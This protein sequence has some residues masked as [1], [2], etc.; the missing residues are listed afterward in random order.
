MRLNVTPFLEIENSEVRSYSLRVETRISLNDLSRHTPWVG[1][2]CRTEA[3]PQKIRNES[4][5]LEEYGVSKWGRVRDFL[6]NGGDPT[7]ENLIREQGADPTKLVP[8]S[9]GSELF[10]STVHDVLAE[11]NDLVVQTLAEAVAS[12]HGGKPP[13]ALVELGSGFGD[14]VVM[15]TGALKPVQ[16]IGGEFTESGVEAGT[17]LAQRAGLSNVTFRHFDFNDPATC[18]WI[19]ENA[20]V[21]SLHA[22][23]QIP[24]LSTG[25]LRAIA[26]RKPRCVV[27]LEPLF[28]EKADTLLGTM[29]K[30]YTILNDYNRDL[31]PA[32]RA[33]ETEGVVEITRVKPNLFG[34]VPLNPTSLIQWRARG[35]PSW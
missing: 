32:L 5:V 30:S 10:L 20:I 27:H 35:E 13:E 26:A 14:K 15:N 22:I 24:N 31:L 28:Q 25:T 21:Y 6:K 23:E 11:W 29:Q 33:L 4:Q 12:T 17:Y 7:F 3:F 8:F 9:R 1:R 18:E 16:A 34:L 19:P 2:V